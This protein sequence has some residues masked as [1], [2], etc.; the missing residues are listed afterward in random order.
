[1]TLLEKIS[2]VALPS[3]LKFILGPVSGAY[4]ALP[5]HEIA[6]LTLSGM[7]LSVLTVSFLGAE[8]RRKLYS[9]FPKK[10]TFS[11]RN[12]RL[13]R[14]WRKYGVWGVSFLTPLLFSP[15]GGSLI[16]VS[17]G[18]KKAKIIFSMFV[19]G[20]FWAFFFA[21]MWDFIKNFL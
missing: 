8:L 13:V 17:F 16:A 3:S 19:C 4:W 11:P 20:S 18:E 14:L 2:A 1:M 6:F 9:F 21:Y 7:M 10:R 15:I 12:R 5:A